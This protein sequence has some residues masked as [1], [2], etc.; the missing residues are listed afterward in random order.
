MWIVPAA[1]Q[2]RQCPKQGGIEGANR[3]GHDRIIDS[4]R[5][6]PIIPLATCLQ[7]PIG[8][9]RSDLLD[10]YLDKGANSMNARTLGLPVIVGV[11]KPGKFL[12][13]G[14]T[15]ERFSRRRNIERRASR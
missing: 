10:I 7:R 8:T 14:S 13:N 11:V 2:T 5:D 4:W 15:E 3:G 12:L 9:L 1:A 6:L